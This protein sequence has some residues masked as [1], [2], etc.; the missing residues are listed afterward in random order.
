MKKIIILFIMLFLLISSAE[1]RSTVF[2]KQRR[3]QVQQRREKIL[4]SGN[5]E[6]AYP[7][8]FNV[9]WFIVNNKAYMGIFFRGAR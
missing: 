5:I 7:K 6:N 9:D 1:G 8:K 2:T 3:E 4:K